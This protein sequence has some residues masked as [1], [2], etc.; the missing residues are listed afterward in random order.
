MTKM[1]GAGKEEGRAQWQGTRKDVI[2]RC[3]YRDVV[4]A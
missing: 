2:G 4:C 1:G 3:S